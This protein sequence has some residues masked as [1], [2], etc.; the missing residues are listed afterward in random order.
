M[1]PSLVSE[2]VFENYLAAVLEGDLPQCRKIVETLLEKDVS[3]VDLY[4]NLF[5]RVQYAIGE[6]WAI[7]RISV[8]KEH[9]ATS[10]TE[11]LMT[12]VYPRLF[13]GERSGKRA[14]ISSGPNEYHQLGGKMVADIFE[15]HGWDSY[16]LGA[17]TPAE[18]L[19]EEIGKRP[20]D[21]LAFSVAIPASLAALRQSL[22]TVRAEF[23]TLPV[24]VGGKAIAD[25]V[26]ADFSDL[27]H[28]RIMT[29]LE[30][31]ESFL[32]KPEAHANN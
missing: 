30:E 16:F 28:V 10:I 25:G 2:I 31:L 3:I 19:L 11:S 22:Q 17:N 4:R 6:L 21:L 12:L 26:E 7:N 24:L 13:H 32:E 1:K 5:H 27:P 14:I 20:P 29:T 18:R 8:A 15:T 9:L 23:P